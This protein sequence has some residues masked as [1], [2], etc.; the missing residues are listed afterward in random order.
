MSKPTQEKN[1]KESETQH[2]WMEYRENTALLFMRA[3]IQRILYWFDGFPLDSAEHNKDQF[4]SEM[5]CGQQK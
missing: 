4:C 5:C 1:S 3:E 2:E